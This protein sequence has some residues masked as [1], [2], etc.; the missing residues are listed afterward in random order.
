M[1]FAGLAEAC[2][3]AQQ[4]NGHVFTNERLS[5][6]VPDVPRDWRRIEVT[7]ADLAFRDDAHEASVLLN[8]R[9]SGRDEDVP[10]ASLTDHLIMGTTSREFISQDTIPF[11]AR[12]AL[13]TVMRAKLDGVLLQYDIYVLKKDGCVFDFVYVVE[14]QH[15]T[16]GAPAFEQ[17]VMGIH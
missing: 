12:E 16:E 11:D 5:F 1:A 4:F 14:P 2:G 17:F 7:A 15:F 3:S 8:G 9:C 10:L 13:H 6:R